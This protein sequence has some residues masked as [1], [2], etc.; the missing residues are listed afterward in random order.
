MSRITA[1]WGENRFPRAQYCDWQGSGKCSL[2]EAG[3]DRYIIQNKY[4]IKYNTYNTII[5]RAAGYRE[6]DNT[7][8]VFSRSLFDSCIWSTC[9]TYA[10]RTSECCP[11]HSPHS[12]SSPPSPGEAR[13]RAPNDTH[14]VMSVTYTYTGI[15]Q[16]VSC[17]CHSQSITYASM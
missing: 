2:G 7:N 9:S 14:D 1:V 15:S 17:I 10:P 4:K 8:T 11:N 5:Q 16:S 13:G 6:R 3:C 12:P